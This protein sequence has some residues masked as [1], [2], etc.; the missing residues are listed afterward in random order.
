MLV[1]VEDF[2]EALLSSFVQAGDLLLVGGRWGQ[3]VEWPG[4]GDALVRSMLIGGG[5]LGCRIYTGVLED[6]PHGGGGDLHSQDQEFTVDTPVHPAR[7]LPD[8]TQDQRADGNARSVACQPVSAWTWR[9]A[10]G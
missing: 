3:W 9:H 6:L 1:F 10:F 2:A 8:Q 5:P 7:I 4:V